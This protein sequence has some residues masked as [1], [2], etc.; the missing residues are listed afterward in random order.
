MASLN[1]ILSGIDIHSVQTKP[2]ER[3]QRVPNAPALVPAD[4]RLAIIGEA[5]GAEE[6]NERKP[7]VGPAGKFLNVLMHH[8]GINRHAIFMGNVC[9][10]RPPTNDLSAWGWESDEVQESLRILAS[11][12]A[13]FDPHCILLLGKY[14]QRAATGDMR[15][16]SSW[17]GTAFKCNLIGSP[18]FGRKCIATYHPAQVLRTYENAPLLRF[19]LNKSKAQS[20]YPDVRI[21]VRNFDIQ[22]RAAQIVERLDAIHLSSDSVWLS[23]DLEGYWNRITRFSVATSPTSGFI[24]PFTQGEFGSAWSPDEEMAIW[25]ATSRV[26]ANPRIPKVLQNSLYD[27]FVLAYQ[28]KVLIRN[29]AWDTMLAH[30]EMYAELEKNLG[31]QASIYTEEP[32][33]KEDRESDDLPTK[34]LYCC[35]DSAVTDEIRQSQAAELAKLPLALGHFNFNME[36]LNPMLYMELRGLCYD[37]AKALVSRSELMLSFYE[38]QHILNLRAKRDAATILFKGVE[39]L[40]YKACIFRYAKENLCKKREA[41]FLS[42]YAQ[43]P[44]AA[45]KD[46]REACVRLNELDSLGLLDTPTSM[47]LGEVES[48]LEIG[49]NVNSSKQMCDWLYVVAGFERQWKEDKNK[50]LVLTADVEACLT[51][52]RKTKDNVPKTILQI[53]SLLYFITTLGTEVDPDGRIRCGYNLVGTETGRLSCYASPTGSGYNLQTVTKKLRYLFT[54]DPGKWFFQCDLAGADGWTV[55]AHCTRVGDDTMQ[56]DY[57]AGLKPAKILALM[58]ELG[59]KVNELS[60][61][62]LKVLCKRV[63]QDGW[64]YFGCKRVQHGS[65]YKMGPTTMS[66]QI[67]KDSYKFLGEPIYV[68][69]KDTKKLQE[70][71]FIRYWGVPKWHDVIAQ[72]LLAKAELTAA[73]GRT[74][75][76]FGRLR[77]PDG[78]LNHDTW[79]AALSNEPQD[80]TTYACNMALHKC[81]HDPQ[82][83][84]A[85][86]SLIIEPLHQVHDAFIG[87]FPRERAEWAA[88]RIRSYFDTPLVIAGQNIIIPFE[89]AYG[90][91]WKELTAGTI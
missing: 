70:L 87:Q 32:Y 7:F 6:A 89:G 56:Q 50:K 91:N 57:L 58:Y 80:N 5:P 73:S 40:T 26:L 23:F 41:A 29:V 82:N 48:L 60:R 34:F 35:K 3:G 8:A 14:A 71:Y 21:P 67:L 68:E 33:W 24:V 16:L 84:T 61:E 30:W 53:R 10:F 78:R 52:Y 51:L 20:H 66:T 27:R 75:K 44:G 88:E 17:R 36:L 59:A 1:S 38:K 42:T 55:A 76:F 9:Q 79:K 62:E 83:R 11:E 72:Q 43:L 63:D 12:I 15:S 2:T 39:G 28:H 54:A 77:D 4:Y 85:T 13:A 86:G 22:L 46:Y 18:F 25:K 37:R 81:W 65:N 47:T 49:L 31:L 74:R 45:L 64:L 69:Y 19:D 90:P